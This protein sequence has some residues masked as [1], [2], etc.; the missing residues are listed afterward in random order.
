MQR[1]EEI[2]EEV[3]LSLTLNNLRANQGDDVKT[4]S[5]NGFI[6]TKEYV[7]FIIF[8]VGKYIKL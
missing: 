1:S 3:L 2:L 7:P 6:E 5:C 8:A 4:N